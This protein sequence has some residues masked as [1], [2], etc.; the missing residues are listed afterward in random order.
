MEMT[1]RREVMIRTVRPGT[2]SGGH[3]KESHATPTNRLE[4]KNSDRRSAVY[5]RVN[6]SVDTPQ[7]YRLTVKENKKG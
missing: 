1:V 6:V 7:G 5:L 4:G 3:V 2:T